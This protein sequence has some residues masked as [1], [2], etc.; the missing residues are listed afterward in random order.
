MKKLLAA[1]F[2]FGASVFGVVNNASATNCA[3]M[4][5][6]ITTTDAASCYAKG[7]I[8][9]TSSGS[10][11]GSVSTP[12]ATLASDS[13]NISANI[14]TACAFLNKVDGTYTLDANANLSTEAVG[15]Y[16]ATVTATSNGNVTVSFTDI[17]QFAT[18]PSLGFTPT[19]ANYV[20]TGVGS[21]QL[22]PM[23]GVIANS[24][25]AGMTDYRYHSV[26]SGG[27]FP[28]GAYQ[29]TTN[30]TCQ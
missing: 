24:K 29:S 3:W 5:G 13:L 7:G 27:V 26:V 23:N 15:A 4:G 17:N 20:D 21:A 16:P 28:A 2:V 25:S 10:G 18:S 9:D 22:M 11:S 12:S 1:L 8:P 14:T 30:L 19:F 6:T